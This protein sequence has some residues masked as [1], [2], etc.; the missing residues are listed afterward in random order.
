MRGHVVEFGFESEDQAGI[1]ALN[2]LMERLQI[3]AA[4]GK[5][6]QA[7]F[8]TLLEETVWHQGVPGVT[9][10]Q[11]TPAK[12]EFLE[13]PTLVHRKSKLFGGGSARLLRIR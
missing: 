12:F 8:V 5:A 4:L 3:A 10:S 1:K 13:D 6:K 7:R 2:A 9:E 11:E